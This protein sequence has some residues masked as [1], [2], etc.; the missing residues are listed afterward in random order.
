MIGIQA[1]ALLIDHTSILVY[2]N[3]Y[4]SVILAI[5]DMDAR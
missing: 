5:R 2:Y 1:E 4:V 3:W